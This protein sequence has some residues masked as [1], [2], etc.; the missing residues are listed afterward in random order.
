[1][2]EYEPKYYTGDLS[3]SFSIFWHSQC[4]EIY[5]NIFR[6][7]IFSKCIKYK[8]NKTPGYHA[9]VLLV[10]T[11]FKVCFRR[12]MDCVDFF[13]SSPIEKNSKERKS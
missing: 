3:F 4:P 10:L 2:N 12:K 6:F 1:M 5:P 8:K 9:D 7:L 13:T 11:L